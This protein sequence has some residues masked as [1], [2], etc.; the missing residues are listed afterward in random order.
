MKGMRLV[1][2]RTHG[3]NLPAATCSTGAPRSLSRR[4][5]S[6]EK[7]GGWGEYT[8]SKP[9]KLPTRILSIGRRGAIS[10]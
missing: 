7:A 9:W 1:E 3:M 4:T 6:G 5:W 2:R 10:G 8:R